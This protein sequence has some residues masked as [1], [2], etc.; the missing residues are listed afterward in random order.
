MFRSLVALN[1][2]SQRKA[3]VSSSRCNM[4]LMESLARTADRTD[5]RLLSNFLQRA[6]FTTKTRRAFRRNTDLYS[7]T[8]SICDKSCTKVL[9]LFANSTDRT[10]QIV[11]NRRF[12]TLDVRSSLKAGVDI[13]VPQPR[14]DNSTPE[15]IHSLIYGYESWLWQKG[16]ESTINAVE[17]R[18][19]CGMSLKD[20]CSKNDDRERC[21][22]K[23]DVV[24]R[25]E[26]G[27]LR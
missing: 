6:S 4:M 15:V 22:L 18:S 5:R 21:A 24:T 26:K 10:N 3:Q 13:L 16:N 12:K 2:Y 17:M 11:K 27:M 14:D 9:R 19:P 1:E 20:I 7:T 23:E 8:H 25:V